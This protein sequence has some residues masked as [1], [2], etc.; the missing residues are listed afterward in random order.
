[1]SGS[2]GAAAGDIGERGHAEL[3]G[4]GASPQ[5]LVDLGELVLGAGEA[6]LESF[7]FAEPALLFGFGDAG[8]E[9]VA[10]LDQ[11]VALFWICS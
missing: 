9:V 11:P 1:V 5:G 6:Y 2:P 3:D 10:D 8:V 4:G 7:D